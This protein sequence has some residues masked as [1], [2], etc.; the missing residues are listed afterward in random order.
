MSKITKAVFPVAGLGTRFLPATKAMPKEMLPIV[1]KPLIQYAVEEAVEAGITEL[2]FVIGRTKRAIPDHFDKAYELE[3]ELENRGKQESLKLV[4]NIVPKHVTCVYL[5]QAEA[6]GLGHAVLCTKQVIGNEPFA[7][8]LA[9]DLIKSNTGV[10]AQMAAQFGRLGSSILGV[11]EV[12]MD[13]TGNYGIIDSE[14]KGNKNLKKISSII[15][16]PNP[17]DAPSNQAV[18]GRYILSSGIFKYLEKIKPG[19][20]GEIQLTDAIA[21]L[22]KSEP[23]YAFNF[24]GVRYDCGSKIGYLKA[25][26]DYAL[27]HPALGSEFS[28]Y[29][30]SKKT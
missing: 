20:G 12:D 2:I 10:V 21:M 15:E 26:V 9:D 1:D 25:T 6:R 24:E 7:V 19:A 4:R 23:V 8:L 14:E 22:M 11:Q 30:K 5:R 13:K 28:E 29:L 18:I 27:D 16:K 17:A 3:V